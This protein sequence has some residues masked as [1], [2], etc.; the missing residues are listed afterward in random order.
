MPSSHWGKQQQ[1]FQKH[2]A[3]ESRNPINEQN[4]AKLECSVRIQLGV[5]PHSGYNYNDKA[6][7]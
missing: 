6:Q 4:V 2:R 7:L 1:R 5:P 3:Y